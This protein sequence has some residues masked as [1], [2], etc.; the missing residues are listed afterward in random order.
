MR[1]VG[2][3]RENEEASVTGLRLITRAFGGGG[4]LTDMNYQ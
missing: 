2:W 1:R 3:V 4:S